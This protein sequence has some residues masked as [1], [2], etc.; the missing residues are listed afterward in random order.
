MELQ[1]RGNFPRRVSKE[2]VHVE[3]AQTKI[4]NGNAQFATQIWTEPFKSMRQPD[5]AAKS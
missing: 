3:Q 4:W 2:P 5:V 1:S